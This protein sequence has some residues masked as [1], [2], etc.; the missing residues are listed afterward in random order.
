MKYL[1]QCLH[2][3]IRVYPTIFLERRVA[4]PYKVPGTDLVLP[5]GSMVII[6]GVEISKD[7]ELFKNPEVYNPDN[8]SEEETKKRGPFADSTFGHGPRNCVGKRFALL[9]LKVAMVRILANYKLV[10]CEKTVDKLV[11][12]TMSSNFMPKGGMW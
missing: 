5:T 3:A 10:P 7:P 9:Q 12:D 4:K 6:P 11:V 1:D 2:E 8:F